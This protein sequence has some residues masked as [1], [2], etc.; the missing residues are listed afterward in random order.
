MRDSNAIDNSQ[1]VN[2]SGNSMTQLLGCFLPVFELKPMHREELNGLL[3]VGI[4][5]SVQERNVMSVR[6]LDYSRHQH[7]S[8]PFPSTRGLN[9]YVF[10]PNFSLR[11]MVNR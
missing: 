1:L 7:G 5:C 2:R 6:V 9:G 10:S 11:T 4:Q 3:F 8:N